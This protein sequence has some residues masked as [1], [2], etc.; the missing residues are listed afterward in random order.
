[1]TRVAQFPKN[2]CEVFRVSMDEY[3]G[4]TLLNVRVFYQVDDGEMRPG[5]QGVAVQV[6]KVPAFL[7]AIQEVMA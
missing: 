6:E 4:H 3:Q 1:M 2:N 7:K 5:R